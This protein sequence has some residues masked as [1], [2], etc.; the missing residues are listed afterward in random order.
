MTVD[1]NVTTTR[2]FVP[3]VNST[4][5]VTSEVTAAA[6]QQCFINTYPSLATLAAPARTTNIDPSRVAPGDGSAS[7]IVP[8]GNPSM[9]PEEV[10]GTDAEDEIVSEATTYMFEDMYGI[11]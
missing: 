6:L 9:T 2:E 4:T 11:D 5:V 7:Q 10:T 3:I 8:T 1:V